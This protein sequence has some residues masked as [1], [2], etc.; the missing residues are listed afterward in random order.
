VLPCQEAPVIDQAG[1]FDGGTI[2]VRL[3]SMGWEETTNFFAIAQRLWSV[4]PGRM[5]KYISK[6]KNIFYAPPAICR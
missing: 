1:A 4:K 5:A 3:L 6:Q 2:E